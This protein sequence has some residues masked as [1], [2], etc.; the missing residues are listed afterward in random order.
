MSPYLSAE[1]IAALD[2]VLNRQEDAE[3]SPRPEREVL[4]MHDAI[5][6]AYV[7]LSRPEGDGGLGAS[8]AEKAALD[9]LRPFA[10]PTQSPKQ[11]GEAHRRSFG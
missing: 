11:S 1:V 4:D 5:T 10:Q 3:A 2:A 7:L 9:V 8:L 6:E